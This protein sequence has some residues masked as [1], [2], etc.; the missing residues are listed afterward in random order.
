[1]FIVVSR[2]RNN[3]LPPEDPLPTSNPPSRAPDCGLLMQ[4]NR[5]L[6]TRFALTPIAI[7]FGSE[8]DP[9]GDFRGYSKDIN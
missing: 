4:T 1:M 2:F 6:A 3:W 7:I 5:H 8:L 9:R